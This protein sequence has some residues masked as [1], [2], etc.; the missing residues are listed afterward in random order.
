MPLIYRGMLPADGTDGP[1]VKDNNANALGVRVYPPSNTPDVVTY[2][3]DKVPWVDP[4]HSAAPQGI[5]VASQSGCNLPAHR[6]PPGEPWNGTGH[7]KL[8]MW[9][10]DTSTL[11]PDQL[12]AVAAPLADQ[13]EHAVISPAVQMALATYR[14]YI[15]GTA[16]NWS[17]APAPSTHCTATSVGR[18][19][20][21]MEPHLEQLA[22]SVAT[23]AGPIELIT[24]LVNANRRGVRAATL[25]AGLEAAVQRAEDAGNDDGAE[26]LRSLLDRIT[27]YC[28]PSARIQ[29]S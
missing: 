25:V 28:A 15:A 23:G 19:A 27:G 5:S 18:G 17:K 22:D 26:A 3:Q 11:V 13:P 2:D 14:G 12:A 29:L 4:V 24:A 10:L 16:G 9:Q 8:V 7:K 6:R 21:S 20:A 1:L